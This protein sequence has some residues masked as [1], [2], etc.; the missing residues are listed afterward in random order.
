MWR[1]LGAV[2][3]ATAAVSGVLFWLVRNVWQLSPY[4]PG[5]TTGDRSLETVL[6]KAEMC[7]RLG[8]YQEAEAALEPL[9]QAE[10]P[11]AQALLLAARTALASR[12]LDQAIRYLERVPDDRS[13]ELVNTLTEAGDLLWQSGHVRSAE[14]LLRRAIAQDPHAVVP[15]RR[16]A[17]LWN[18]LGRRW[19]SEPLLFALLKTNQISLE[20]LILLGDLWPDYNLP[21]ETN[22]YLAAVPTDPLPRLAAARAAAHRF[23]HGRARKWLEE[24]IADSP[25][26]VEAHVW[27]G[28]T[29]VQTQDWQ[30]F[31]RWQEQLPQQCS[32][33]PHLWYVLGLAAQSLGQPQAAARCFWEAVRR[34][35]NHDQANYQLAVVL[36]ALQ[37]R[38]QAEIYRR[39]AELLFALA[40]ELKDV[41]NHREEL[42]FLPQSDSQLRRVAELCEQLGRIWEA[43]Q[44]CRVALSLRPHAA[45][46]SQFVARCDAILAPDTPRVLPEKNP[47]HQVELSHFP[48]PRFSV[49]TLSEAN[50]LGTNPLPA[51]VRFVDRAEEAGISFVAYNGDD[52]T[53]PEIRLLETTGCGVGVID[54][55]ADGWPDLYFAQACPWPPDARLMSYQDRLFHNLGQGTFRDVTEQAGLGDTRFSQ[56]V[57]V[58]DYNDDGFPDIF[59][60]NLGANRLYCNNGDGTFTDVFEGSPIAGDSWTTSAAVADVNGDGY[61]DLYEVNYLSGDA[62]SRR[63]FDGQ[64]PRTCPPSLFPAAADRLLLNRGDGRFDDVSQE[65]GIVAPNGK[66]LGI[67]VAD[68]DNSN[69]LSIFVANDGTPNFFYVPRQVLPDG[70]CQFENRAFLTGLAC[71]RY[72]QYQACMGVAVGDADQDGW[73]DLFVTNFYDE[74]NTLYMNGHHGTVFTDETMDR[75]LGYPSLKMLGFGTQFLDAELD[76]WPDL[77]VTNGHIEDRTLQGEPYRMPAQFF[78]NRGHGYFVPLPAEQVGPFFG[79]PL[80][81]RGMARL[82][83]NND[84]REDVVISHSLDRAALLTNESEPAG[85]CLVIELRGVVSSR[86]AVGA[87]VVVTAAGRPRLGQITAGDGYMASNQKQLVFG[88]GPCTQVDQLEVIWPSGLHQTWH[89]PPIDHRLILV[90]GHTTWVDLPLRR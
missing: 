87:K 20:E 30:A 62:L 40:A 47:A 54:F 21:A 66:G 72:G 42:P 35:P 19:E 68:L 86:D 41:Y 80:L 64:R 44:W 31:V 51:S 49:Q 81:G 59:L 88:L 16:L 1:T 55:D 60:A 9:I 69:R 2:L 6:A 23:D 53:T 17:F 79:R 11:P 4:N 5:T 28:W 45:W 12:K 70:L 32:H 84:G 7:L 82:D 27:L 63:C 77:I 61:P 3:I 85:H 18:V 43:R 57:A 73:L 71:D 26:L 25:D 78:H 52:P 74:P 89:N 22:R 15:L 39:H 34:D 50:S 46:A 13:P 36:A 90:E 14:R 48:L 24:I 58:G 37:E 38:E 76:G 65:A 8:Q 83:W 67:V 29:L 75:G 56:G 10:N 33:H